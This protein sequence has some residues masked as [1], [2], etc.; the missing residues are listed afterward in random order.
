MKKL[1]LVLVFALS[2]MISYGQTS[3]Y[4]TIQ[5]AKEYHQK[6]LTLFKSEPIIKS[7][8]IFL[9]N[10]I[11]QFGNWKTLCSD[12]TIINRGIA[13]DN[14][15][16]VLARLDDVITRQ[17][18][19]LFLKI[20]INDISQ[21]IPVKIISQNIFEIIKRIKAK[22]PT[23]KIYVHSIL[24]TN[25]QVKEY[26]PDAFNKDDRVTL[27]NAQ[28]RR[29]AKIKKYTYVDL[30][31]VLKDKDGKLDYRYAQS[32]GLHLNKTGYEKWIKILKGKGYL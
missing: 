13:G 15:F 23:T 1:L 32:D 29:N 3:G 12:S 9:G 11:T 17:P 21:N 2:S 5:Y 18:S 30:H 26:Y 4:D 14:T 7:K 22:S 25:D 8:V 31:K 24:P 27:V 28:L 20:G 19:K 16:G 10:S 6:R